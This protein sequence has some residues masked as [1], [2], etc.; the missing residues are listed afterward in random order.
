MLIATL[1]RYIEKESAFKRQ[2]GT[3]IMRRLRRKQRTRRLVL[4][5]IILGVL[6]TGVV[7]ALATVSYVKPQDV[8]H[9]VEIAKKSEIPIIVSKTAKSRAPEPATIALFGGGLIGMLAGFVRRTY[10]AIKRVF[11]FCAAI[12]GIILAAPI[13]ILTA[14]LVKLTSKGPVV[15]SQTRVGRGG[16]HFKIYKFRTM[17]T[18]AEK[19]TG[20]VWATKHDARITPI[21]RFLRKSRI[22]ELPQ[23]FNI[24]L[25]NMSLI[26]PRPERPV[27]VSEFTEKI[28]DYEHRLTV[29]P[30]ITGLAQVFHRYDEDIKDVRKKVKYDILYI[31]KMNLAADFGIV[32]RTVGVVLTGFGAK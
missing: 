12:I 30:G 23:F 11:D 4:A 3:K 8:T 28:S 17:R 21:G 25:G 9:E 32:L 20:P 31:K 26:G 16:E 1:N 6:F 19:E 15:Y 29:K 27:F 18:D 2:N 10:A 7:S 5:S 13:M 22:D 14:M 24:L